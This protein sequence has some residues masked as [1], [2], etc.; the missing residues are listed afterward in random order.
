MRA[1]DYQVSPRAIWPAPAPP[2]SNTVSRLASYAI[3]LQTRA[4]ALPIGW[5]SDQSIPSHS[6]V[7]ARTPVDP[8]PPADGL[9]P[10]A[11]VVAVTAGGERRVYAYSGIANRCDAS[12]QWTDELGGVALIFEYSADSET[13]MVA[14]D[15]PDAPIE[16]EYSFWFAWYA[17]YPQDEVLD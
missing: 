2:N 15:P 16:V 6:Q 9:A 4:H 1:A 11:R 7:S 12:G 17:M 13:V 5:R 10:K 14:P 8:A 3:E